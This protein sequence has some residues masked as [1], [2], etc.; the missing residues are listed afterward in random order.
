MIN[1]LRDKRKGIKLSLK[2]ILFD[3]ELDSDWVWVLP[4]QIS[5]YQVECSLRDGARPVG[6]RGHIA[7]LLGRVGHAQ[8]RGEEASQAD[9]WVLA[10]S[11]K[12]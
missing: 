2:Q 8:K 6:W 1:A 12:R 3:Y 10:H 9:G 5:P 4:G 7:G 11:A